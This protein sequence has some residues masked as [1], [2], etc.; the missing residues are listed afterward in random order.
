MTAVSVPPA[1][2]NLPSPRPG[3]RPC[4]V[5]RDATSE[6]GGEPA[7]GNLRSQSYVA[8]RYRS[9]RSASGPGAGRGLLDDVGGHLVKFSVFGLA[10]PAEPG[11][12]LVGGV[13]AAT[14]EYPDGLIDDWTAL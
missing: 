3:S 6:T 11:E 13:S 5:S 14:A 10:H 4:D 12:R 1:Q 7:L 2:L 9:W 8:C